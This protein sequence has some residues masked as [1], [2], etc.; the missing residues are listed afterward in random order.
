MSL[1]CCHC[2]SGQRSLPGEVC[3]AL[4]GLPARLV[5]WAECVHAEA[6][7]HRH[8]PSGCVMAAVDRCFGESF[9]LNLNGP[10]LSLVPPAAM[11]W[12]LFFPLSGHQHHLQQQQYLRAYFSNTK[13]LP[14]WPAMCRK[15][16]TSP[17]ASLSLTQRG[18]LYRHTRT[19]EFG[20]SH[21]PEIATLSFH[22]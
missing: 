6:L 1:G 15:Q 16:N 8:A 22:S 20:G 11:N 12:D 4:H 19:H 17:N 9:L 21:Q 2:W 10:S 3:V 14:M 18:L 7:L 5:S 13:L